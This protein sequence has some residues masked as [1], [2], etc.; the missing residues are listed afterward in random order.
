MWLV[1]ALIMGITNGIQGIKSFISLGINLA[2][3]IL[4][5]RL[6]SLGF[7][8]VLVVGV[9]GL[10]VLWSTIYFG[11][12]NIN[13]AD[14]TFISSLIVII[15]ISALTFLI[16]SWAQVQGFGEENTSELEGMLLYGRL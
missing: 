16:F 9:C 2:I 10:F 13:I 15:G 6:L 7:S 5:I 3:I 12:V 4:M 8:F 11:V 1:L 14:A